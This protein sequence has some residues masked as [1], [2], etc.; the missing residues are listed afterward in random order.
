MPEKKALTTEAQRARRKAKPRKCHGGIAGRRDVEVN[1][2]ISFCA[3]NTL[4]LLWVFLRVLC[5]SVVKI[6]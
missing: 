6:D 4:Y 5:A 2:D 3:A 1:T